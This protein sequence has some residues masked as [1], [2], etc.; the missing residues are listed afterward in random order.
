M[1]LIFGWLVYI[2]LLGALAFMNDPNG[3]ETSD[4]I[5]AATAGIFTVVDCTG[6]D[7][8]AAIKARN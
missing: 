6:K 2:I 7:I 8:I 3:L 4:Y 1:N 5:V